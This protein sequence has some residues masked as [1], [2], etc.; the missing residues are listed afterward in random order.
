MTEK[1]FAEIVASALIMVLRALNRRYNL[2][3]WILTRHE[4]RQIEIAM[5][6]NGEFI[7]PE[8]ARYFHK[9]I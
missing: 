2:R 5:N 1:E 4:K 3:M 6:E 8:I 9:N 7:P